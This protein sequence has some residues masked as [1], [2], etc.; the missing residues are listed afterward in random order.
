MT[1][2]RKLSLAASLAL[3]GNTGVAATFT[4]PAHARP[5]SRHP[6]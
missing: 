6:A 3:A 5:A 2:F 4:A 1:R